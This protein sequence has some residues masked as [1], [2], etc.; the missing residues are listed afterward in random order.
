[1]A[2]TL[3]LFAG[4]NTAREPY[5]PTGSGLIGENDDVPPTENTNQNQELALVYYPGKSLN[6]YTATDHTNRVLLSLIY[7][8]LFAV[9]SGYEPRPILCQSYNV[10]AD[11]KT[12]TFYL[13]DA[14]FSDGT[15]VTAAD[16][17]ASLQAAQG[18]PWYGGRLQHVK[19]VSGFGNAVVVELDT[20]MENLPI[21]LDIPIVKASEVEA[22]RPL[23][24]GPYRLD[25]AGG[26]L[27]RQAGWWCSARLPIRGDFI[28]LIPVESAAD[29]RDA[30]EF[31]GASLVCMDPASTDYVMFRSDYELWDSENGQFLY[32]A[33]NSKSKVFSNPTVRAALTHAIDR[34]TL[35]EAYYHGF[36]QPATLPVSP[37]SPWYNQT[38]AA[39]F[40]YDPEKFAQAVAGALETKAIETNEVTLLVNS[41]DITR[42]RVG[43]AIAKMLE[44]GG[45]KVTITT[46]TAANFA[47]A[48]KAENY[49]LY[50]GQ[51]RLSQNMDLTAFFSKNGTLNYGNMYAPALYATGLEAL[52]NAGNFY[53]LYQGVMENG[54]L[55]PILFQ[56]Y[57]LFT[58]RGALSSLEPAR[59]NLFYYD[60]G[61][62][63]ADAQNTGE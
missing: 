24:T 41:S 43:L 30:F 59:D 58:K 56:S 46:A 12:Y 9:N 11:M 25:T 4:C 57:A 32:L 1:M 44:A 35:A 7:Q 15:Q 27:R 34:K 29:I 61:R 33:C 16:A 28:K 2:L 13:A 48:L 36:A 63:L 18:S 6:P 21:L 47:E 51:T 50:L 14:R 42:H 17:A 60:L 23:G 3:G 40:A 54:Q 55:C 19:T 53:D 8:G 10:S 39:R 20:P 62:S 38:L 31:G 22:A 52:A 37:E 26:G 49:D 5:T 45:L